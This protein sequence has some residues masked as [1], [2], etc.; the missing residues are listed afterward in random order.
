MARPRKFD[1]AAVVGAARLQFWQHGYEGTSMADLCAATG[2]ASQS[3]Y[4]AFG[5]KHG[6]F[7]RTLEDYCTSQL[8]GLEAGE[9]AAAGPWAWLMA[10]V[11]F[12]DGG[13]LGL[14]RDGCY[15]SGS[16]VALA[17]LDEDV[18]QASRRTYGRML[19]VFTTAL[20]RASTLGELQDGVD[21]DSVALALLA[22]MQGIEF[23]AKSGL[24]DDQFAQAKAATVAT[25]TRAYGAGA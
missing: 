24:P 2:V 12:D 5:S 16:A 15:L 9:H 10:A 17:R 11:V 23:L 4:G 13:R 14:G 8:D 22:A 1:E 7:I 6:L 20:R 25:L 3:L 19:D 18:Q 21:I